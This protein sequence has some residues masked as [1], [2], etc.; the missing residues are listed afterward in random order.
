MVKSTPGTDHQ[1]NTLHSQLHSFLASGRLLTHHHFRS[2]HMLIW[3]LSTIPI[4]AIPRYS[5]LLATATEVPSKI[6]GNPAGS[7]S[8]VPF[9]LPGCAVKSGILQHGAEPGGTASAGLGSSI[10]RQKVSFTM[11]HLQSPHCKSA[12]HLKSHLLP[13]HCN[14]HGPF[15]LSFCLGKPCCVIFIPVL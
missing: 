9:A 11:C 14:L 6:P 7:P 12:C 3:P 10:L 4:P 5:I 8:V 1:K 15:V 2:P 13:S